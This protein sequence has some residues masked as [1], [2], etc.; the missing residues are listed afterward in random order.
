MPPKMPPK[1]LL[2]EIRS[3]KLEIKGQN[4]LL[5]RLQICGL[6]QESDSYDNPN[7]VETKV[8]AFEPVEGWLCFQS[9]VKSF[10]QGET[11]PYAG[12]LLYG[13]VVNAKGESLHIREDGL[14]GWILTK[15]TEIDEGEQYLAETQKFLGLGN[16]QAPEKLYYR[17]YWENDQE[18]GY[19]Q[20]VARFTGFE[21]EES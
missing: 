14:G 19:R 8:K 1:E 2:K 20:F 3:K 16:K 4:N 21:P 18:H 10:C 12:I 5:D 6:E 13:E 15:L 11:M 7:D 17:V 9:E